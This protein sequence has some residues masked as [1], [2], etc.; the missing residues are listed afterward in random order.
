MEYVYLLLLGN[1]CEWE[2][3]IILLSMEHAISESI[4]HPNARVEIF[5]K[6][7]EQEYTPTYDYYKNGNLVQASFLNITT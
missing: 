2:D 6:N 4:K 7:N 1:G 5:S 3:M